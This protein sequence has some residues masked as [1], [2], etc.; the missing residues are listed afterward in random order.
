MPRDVPAVP[1]VKVSWWAEQVSP[2]EISRFNGIDDFRRT[3][4]EDYVAVVR[5][6]PGDLGGLYQMA[7]HFVSNITLADVASFIAAGVAYDMLKSGSKAFLL[8]PFLTAFKSLSERNQSFDIGIEE[9]L[10]EFQDSIVAIDGSYR[11]AIPSQIE[12]ILNTIAK[13][14]KT[15]TLESGETPFEIRIPVFE[16]TAE[17]RPA[18]FR[19]LL[20]VDE[21]LA[22]GTTEDYS[23]F[24][25]L[26]YDYSRKYRVF[27]VK[28]RLLVDDKFLSRSYY[29]QIM[30]ERWREQ[31]A[32]SKK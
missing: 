17:D 16:D 6:R 25:G 15:F 32:A 12:F 31:R 23:G 21:T 10:M 3:L 19:A 8:R 22:K 2:T 20:E 30:E 9:L 24:W 27:D 7:V 13:N 11:D 14:Y 29:W 28:R 5:P 18:R 26:W 4:D 1:S